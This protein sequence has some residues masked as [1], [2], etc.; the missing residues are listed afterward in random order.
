M[1]KHKSRL[2]WQRSLI[3]LGLQGGLLGISLVGIILPALADATAPSPSPNE[4]VAPTPSAAE[5][6]DLSPEIIED[7]PVLQEWLQEVPDVLSEIKH[8]PSF[9]TRVRAGYSQFPS[10]DQAAGWHVGVEDIFL[11]ET[12]LTLSADYQATFTNDSEEDGPDEREAYGVD[13]RYYVRPLGSYVNIAPV[14][15]YRNLE[16]DLYA[17]DGVHVGVRVLWVLSRTGAADIA[18]TQSWVSPGSDEEVGLTTLSFGY[19]VTENLRLSTDIQKQNSRFRKDSRVGLS[20]E[21]MP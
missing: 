2:K 15:G 8:D 7:S 5:A 14:L 21:W 18:V 19:A 6:L 17:T 10:A 11:G 3:Q 12:G 20:V 4:T 9:R 13:L 1:E 16:T